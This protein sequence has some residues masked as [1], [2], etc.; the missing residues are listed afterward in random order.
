MIE[1]INVSKTYN[2]NSITAVENLTLSVQAGKIFGFLGP[3]GAGKSTTIKML[4]GIL[5]PDSGSIKLNNINLAENPVEAKNIIGYVPDEPALYEKMS[6]R[7]FLNFIADIYRMDE[8]SRKTAGAI[9]GEFGIDSKLSE[10][11]SSYSHGMKQ[12]L[13]ITAALMHN[14]EIFILD[15]PMS[16][17]DPQSA[18]ILK[19]RMREL[20][21][22][23]KT[24]FFS[25]HVMEVAEKICDEV[26]IIKDGKIIACGRLE[27]IRKEKHKD[28]DESLEKMFLELTNENTYSA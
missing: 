25:T 18:F 1:I 12:K 10:A 4:T 16:G 24:V 17:L 13:S 6:G 8:R 2:K 23:G 7:D 11:I 20:C 26:G 5:N 9:A 27:D 22:E 15:E 14:P 21:N 28:G 3:N 19:R